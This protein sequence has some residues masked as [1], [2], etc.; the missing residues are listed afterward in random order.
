MADTKE[1]M[2]ENRAASPIPTKDAYGNTDPVSSSSTQE[3]APM[4]PE[5]EVVR[6]KKPW[7]NGFF[8]M[9]HVLQIIVAAVLA[10]ALG[11]G[12]SSAVDVPESARTII[13]IP[14]VMWLRCLQAI[15]RFL[16]T[17]VED[18]SR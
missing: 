13:A 7:W 9:G 5:D 2:P 10:I 4:Y 3:P 15:G 6:E 11:L 18:K 14:G 12:I 1:V 17:I 16:S 8:V